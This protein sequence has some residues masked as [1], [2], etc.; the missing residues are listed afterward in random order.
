M[1]KLGDFHAAVI[2]LQN[3]THVILQP[4]TDAKMTTSLPHQPQSLLV[5]LL[6]LLPKKKNLRVLTLHFDYLCS[7]HI[8][9]RQ[10]STEL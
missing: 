3:P 10:M 7:W 5:V 1:R 4:R 2:H 9:R 6:A 8:H